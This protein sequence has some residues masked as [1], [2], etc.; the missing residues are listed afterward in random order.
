MRIERLERE[1]P[2]RERP[3]ALASDLLMEEARIFARYLA[4]HARQNTD[5][6]IRSIGKAAVKGDE[7]MAGYLIYANRYAF[8]AG[9]GDRHAR[10]I[11]EIEY[12]ASRI[13]SELRTLQQQDIV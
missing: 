6:A 12:A 13:Q 9:R 2:W 10:L 5:E 4:R 11:S 1:R 3:Y 7:A 8:F